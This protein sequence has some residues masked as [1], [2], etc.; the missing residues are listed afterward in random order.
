MV[1]FA[2]NIHTGGGKVLLD[3]LISSEPFGPIT[4][5][6]LDQRYSATN[7]SAAIKVYRFPPKLISRLWAQFV[8]LKLIGAWA[9]NE[10]PIILFFGNNPPLFR[11]RAK[12]ILYLQNC[13]LLSGVPL[14]RDSVKVA[15]RNLIERYMLKIFRK[16]V[17]EIWVQTDWMVNLVRQQFNKTPVY[18]KPF[19]PRLPIATATK[20]VYDIITVSSLSPHKNFN[21]FIDALKFLD[22]QLRRAITVVAVL[23]TSLA[24]GQ[25]QAPQFKNISLQI[26]SKLPRGELIS[27]YQKCKLAAITSSY[28]SFCLPLYE[29]SHFGL[30]IVALDTPFARE[31]S[32]NILFYSAN[33]GRVLA[34]ALCR[35]ILL[36]SE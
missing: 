12:C 29:A 20:K 23:D 4:H 6:F 11:L 34:D 35:A 28:E 31:I 25:L 14:P 1:L 17:D 8:L 21:T 5:L 33:D 22:D 26:E 9:G 32:D 27:M 16:N 2:I 24:A 30:P 13:F 36:D 3:E 7:I 19:L 15:V 10:T 18:K